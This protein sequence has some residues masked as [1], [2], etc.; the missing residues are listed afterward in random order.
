MYFILFL[1]CFFLV[2]YIFTLCKEGIQEKQL[3]SKWL[4][5]SKNKRNETNILYFTCKKQQLMSKSTNF[6]LDYKVEEP[7]IPKVVY[8]TYHEL[9][10]IPQ[11]VL[12]NI[13]KNCEGCDIRI[14]DDAQCIAFLEKYFGRKAV[15]IFNN[16]KFSAHKADF[17]R[18]CILYVFGGCYFDIKTNFIKPISEI[19]DFTK[20]STWYTVLGIGDK[21]VY[22]GI[23]VTPPRNPILLKCIKHCFRKKRS[24]DYLFFLK[25]IYRC[26]EKSTYKLPKVGLNK[27]KNGWN[28]IL[29][30]ETCL[31]CEENK[32]KSK[33]D[34]YNFNCNIQNEKKEKVFYTRYTDFPWA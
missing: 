28:C 11:Y 21:L 4:D 8:F 27:Q 18:Y 34:R 15:S 23:I 26:I 10:F 9:K 32:C 12:S 17:W 31:N 6:Q 5:L 22:N 20:H 13:E 33:P 7:K 30:Q 2:I 3:V 25:Y 14:F 1:L 19:F 16:M 24:K 29:F